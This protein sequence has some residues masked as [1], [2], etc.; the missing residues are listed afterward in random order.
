[1]AHSVIL[2]EKASPQ[3]HEVSAQRAC[4]V[5]AK[6]FIWFLPLTSDMATTLRKLLTVIF[7]LSTTA[8]TVNKELGNAIFCK[9][10]LS[11]NAQYTIWL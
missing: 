8:V 4:N 3:Q 11:N 5:A 2:A 9:T 10:E 6:L 7:A 1:M